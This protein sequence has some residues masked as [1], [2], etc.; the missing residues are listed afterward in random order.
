MGLGLILSG[1]LIWM[2]RAT[3][4]VQSINNNICYLVASTNI[5]SFPIYSN[6][7]C[8]D[9]VPVTN[10]CNYSLGQW[11]G[12]YCYGSDEIL[13]LI[14]EISLD[15]SFQVTGSLPSE[16]GLI[17][18]LDMLVAPYQ[19][20]SGSIPNSYCNLTS[21]SLIQL[22]A[23]SLTN[24]IPSCLG[25]MT[26]LGS[27]DISFNK[28]IGTIPSAIG[29]LTKLYYLI[30]ENNSLNYTIPSG[31]S[32]LHKLIGLYMNNNE[33]S[34]IIP[35]EYSS[36]IISSMYIYRNNSNIFRKFICFK[37]YDVK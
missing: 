6:W 27:L 10:P 17:T 5:A 28:L 21:L 3:E 9:Y 12:V 11:Y 34:G 22:P 33:L 25:S 37:L 36:N 8:V 26:N 24:T 19:T 16:L 15:M 35:F 20:L 4:I 23:N 13:G 32:N 14:T 29:E 18:S 30:I 7:K 2:L 31:I 1:C